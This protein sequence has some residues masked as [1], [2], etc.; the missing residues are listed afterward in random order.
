MLIL[1]SSSINLLGKIWKNFYKIY[2]ET[3]MHECSGAS[4]ALITILK[5]KLTNFEDFFSG[6]NLHL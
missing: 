5:N 4:M 1:I 6:C 2:K 3:I